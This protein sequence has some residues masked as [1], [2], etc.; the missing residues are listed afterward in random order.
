M[1]PSRYCKAL[2][3]MPRIF[4]ISLCSIYATSLPQSQHH[5]MLLQCWTFYVHVHVILRFIKT[6]KL[7][8]LQMFRVFTVQRSRSNSAGKWVN[9][10][11]DMQLK[12]LYF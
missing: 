12:A 8:G 5:I 4:H 9:L 10:I 2:N 11:K 7:K 3:F 6:A 1:A